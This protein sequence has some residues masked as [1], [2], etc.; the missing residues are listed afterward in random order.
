MDSVLVDL[1]DVN[2]FVRERR[3][4]VV[5]LIADRLMLSCCVETQGDVES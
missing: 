2:D 3:G 4:M 5:V 1:S